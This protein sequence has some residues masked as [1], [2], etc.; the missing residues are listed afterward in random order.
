VSFAEKIKK[1]EG[2]FLFSWTAQ[3]TLNK[4]K[5]FRAWPQ[6]KAQLPPLGEIKILSGGEVLS[7][8]EKPGQILLKN[9][10]AYLSCAQNT[11]V[12]ILEIQPPGKGPVNA[13]SLLQNL[14]ANSGQGP[15]RVLEISTSEKV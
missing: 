11:Q 6:V 5:A 4:I 9:S 15:L 7:G 1:E 14:A 12:E 2:H 8:A 3:E 10:K 13:Y